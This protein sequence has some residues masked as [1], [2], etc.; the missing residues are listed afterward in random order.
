[1]PYLS[2]RDKAGRLQALAELG[3]TSKHLPTT[4]VEDLLLLDLGLDERVL[5]LEAAGSGD[6]RVLEHFLTS[7]FQAAHQD[8]AALAVRLWALKSDHL[9]W[10][11]V[12]A[13]ARAPLVPQR[14]L[15]TALDF[16]ADGGGALLV[17]EAAKREGLEELSPAFWS[18]VL[19]RAVQ[20]NVETP[21]LTK[22]AAK[23]VGELDAPYAP[24]NKAVPAALSYVARFAP[25]E[26]HA[27]RVA[28]R[29]AEPWRDVVRAIALTLEEGE[30][31][32]EV[33]TKLAQKP[34]KTKATFRWLETMPPLWLRFELDSATVAAALTTMDPAADDRLGF[35]PFGGVKEQ[36]LVD[37]LAQVKDDAA[38]GR[39]V[40][41]VLGLLPRPA[42]ASFLDRLKDR[43]RG[44]QDPAQLLGQLP[45]S[46]RLALTG[47]DQALKQEEQD[48]LGR[49]PKVRAAR[50]VEPQMDG[51]D[52]AARRAF[53]DCAFRNL[54]PSAGRAK[55][56]PH[57]FFPLLLDAWTAPTEPKLAALAQASRQVEGVL[58]L[59]YV[60][61]L[62]RFRGEDQAALKTLDFIRSKEEDDLRA[63]AHALDGIGTPRATQELVSTLTRPNVAP[64]LQLEIC[65]ILRRHDVGNLQNEL[66]SAI[67]DLVTRE[68][69][70]AEA[71]EVR[72]ALAGLISPN[73]PQAAGSAPQARSS[74]NAGAS[75][76]ELDTALA[77]KIPHYRELSSEVKRA[78]R[79]S[80]YFHLQVLSTGAPESIDLSPVIDMQYKA[81]ELFFR[82]QFEEPCSRLIHQG[83]L[84]RRLDVIGYA[85]PVPRAMDEFE[86]FVAQLPTIRDI[87]FFSKFKLRKLL[88]AIC[89]FRPGKRFTLDGLKAFALFF[90]CFGRSDCRY[91]LG[92]LFPL[93]LAGDAALFSFCKELHVMQDFR[94]RAAH[95]GFHPDASSDIEGIWRATAEIVQI[96]WRV[97]TWLDGGASVHN[98]AQH[99]PAPII[100]KKVS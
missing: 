56:P 4:L 46:L 35:E 27:L 23:I 59:A 73:A 79:T 13:A 49:S 47:E 45:L 53:F 94:N 83:I 62:G 93:G 77:G 5:L 88:R 25:K 89:Q 90:L 44:S 3:K 2:R 55:D 10:F 40:A 9:M 38:F 43:I 54:A 1:M 11:R 30:A 99:R 86:A 92:G 96:A 76:L 39:A 70:S 48:V 12:L 63:V 29:V 100:E 95:E 26:I 41:R 19:T 34:P 18:L 6:R 50:F 74:P 75:D 14:V 85:R 15:Y 66:R 61:T 20:W 57:G 28:S 65:G 80:Q 60:A 97:K 69:Q 51:P 52:F 98:V 16:A 72:E 21:P 24:D 36:V 67:G 7:Q 37:A 33:L 22:L 31:Q 64:A 32:R 71:R 91:G 58:R 78:L 42:P 82:E 68:G 87:P 17:E 8:L 81:L 84:Q